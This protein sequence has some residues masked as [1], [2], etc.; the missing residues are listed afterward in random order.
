MLDRHN[1]PIQGFYVA[2]HRF[3][4]PQFAPGGE[5]GNIIDGPGANDD[6]V[7]EAILDTYRDGP[8]PTVGDLRVW[9]VTPSRTDDVT[10]WAITTALRTYHERMEARYGE[11]V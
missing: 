4:G 5:W 8:H 2:H 7:I 1:Y 3:T 11:M 9:L 6:D 10:F